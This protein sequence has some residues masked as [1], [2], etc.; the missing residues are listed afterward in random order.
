M[1]RQMWEDNLG[2]TVQG[3]RTEWS[4]LL[5]RRNDNSLPSYSLRWAADYL[6]PQDFYWVLFDSHSPD[7]H[8]GYA[9]PK[10]DALCEAADTDLNPASRTALY[11]QAA[12]ILASDVPAIPIYYQKDPELVKP[13]VGGLDDNLLGHLP[14]KHVTLAPH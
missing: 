14:Y 6:D 7:N 10:F 13:Y 5:S 2:I 1:L 3:E 12:R 11:R 4:V 9:N 8:F